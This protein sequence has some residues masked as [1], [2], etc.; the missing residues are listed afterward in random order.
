MDSFAP[1]RDE[2]GRNVYECARC[3]EAL[4]GKTGAPS[5]GPHICKDPDACYRTA[6]AAPRHTTEAED[7]VDRV[8]RGLYERAMEERQGRSRKPQQF[9]ANWDSMG[10][11]NKRGW[12]D[13]A[14]R[15]LAGEFD[16]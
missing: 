8:A 7:A 10:E 4:T 14:R 12:R 1:N 6:S 5:P 3:G 11:S 13:E 2:W 15:V 16:A 9:E